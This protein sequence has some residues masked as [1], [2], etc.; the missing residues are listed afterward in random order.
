MWHDRVEGVPTAGNSTVLGPR[1]A[2]PVTRKPTSN[3]GA[4]YNY[5][6][7]FEALSNFFWTASY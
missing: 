5:L 1:G 6:L 4:R 3:F 7:R 2:I